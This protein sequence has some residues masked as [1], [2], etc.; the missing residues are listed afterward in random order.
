MYVPKEE[1]EDSPVDLPAKGHS[2]LWNPIPPEVK[3]KI[4]CNVLGVWWQVTEE[5][6][7]WQRGRKKRK[8][9][10]KRVKK[11]KKVTKRKKKNNKKVT[12]RKKKSDKQTNKEE[13]GQTDHNSFFAFQ[14]TDSIPHL[15]LS[16]GGNSL[17]CIYCIYCIT[18]KYI[19]CI[20]CTAYTAYIWSTYTVLSSYICWSGYVSSSLIILRNGTALIV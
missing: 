13:R 4:T 10:T 5:G 15:H 18:V 19:Y 1:E 16:A 20:I 3:P 7:R 17:K 8:K 6:K 2:E 11:P 9:V 12:K 14:V